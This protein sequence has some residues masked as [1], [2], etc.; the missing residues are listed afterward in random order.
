MGQSVL[1]VLAGKV[2]GR[3]AHSQKRSGSK[4]ELK[5]CFESLRSKGCDVTWEDSEGR[6]CLD[7]AAASGA[8]WMLDMFK[9]K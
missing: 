6:T 1:H 7:A 2:L 8:S 9:R 4:E 5:S 3:D